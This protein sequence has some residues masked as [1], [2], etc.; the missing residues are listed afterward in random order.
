MHL[1]TGAMTLARYIAVTRPGSGQVTV[2]REEEL[3]SLVLEALPLPTGRECGSSSTTPA[4]HCPVSSLRAPWS[5]WCST[6]S[7]AAA[8]PAHLAKVAFYEEAAP[9]LAPGGVMVVNVGDDPGLAS[10]ADQA[11]AM[12][13]VSADVWC[14]AGRN[15]GNL[16]LVGGRDPL[17]R[18]WAAYFAAA[19]PHPAGVLAAQGLTELVARSSSRPEFPAEPGTLDAAERHLGTLGGRPGGQRPVGALRFLDE[20]PGGGVDHRAGVPGSG[21]GRRCLRHEEASRVGCDATAAGCSEEYQ[22]DVTLAISATNSST[23][24]RVVSKL[25]IHRT[26]R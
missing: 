19:G 6:S 12:R 2:E 18:E 11:R 4:R 10:L 21:L 20:F 16:V 23:S 1:G 14:L 17:P 13:A 7:P 26:C 22:P 9:L 24:C 8:R 5:R 15:A 25:H 3:P